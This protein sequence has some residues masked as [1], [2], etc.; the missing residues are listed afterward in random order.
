M[1]LLYDITVDNYLGG[2]KRRFGY[3]L[4]VGYNSFL[5]PI[6]FSVARDTRSSEN[7]MN[8]NIGFWFK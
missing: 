7:Q 5:G 2:E 3:G 8:L 1:E 4:S 6:S